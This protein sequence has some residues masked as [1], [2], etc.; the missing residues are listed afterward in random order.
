MAIGFA[1]GE[2][3]AFVESLHERALTAERE[4]ALRVA[5]ARVSERTRIAREMHDVLAHRISLV[6]MHSG[7]LTYRTDLTADEVS[8][9]AEI[10]R[11]NANLALSELRSVLGV[12]REVPGFDADVGDVGP[13]PPQPTLADL[14]ALVAEATSAGSSVTVTTDG[15]LGVVPTQVSRSAYR[16]VQE[17]LTNARKHA[18]GAR[19]EVTVDVRAAPGEPDEPAEMRV[20]VTNPLPRGVPG[21]GDRA[22]LGLVGLTER[23]VLA[24]GQLTHGLDE[25]GNFVVSARLPWTAP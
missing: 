25:H 7:V 13:E 8:Q 18:S 4:Q 19:V 2:R 1:V 5:A 6:A 10:V 11:A 15:D 12:M 21:S 14:D 17:G 16:I 9:T 24:G 23:A 3:R 22:G 20:T